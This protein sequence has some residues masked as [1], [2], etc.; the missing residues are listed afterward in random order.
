MSVLRGRRLALGAVATLLALSCG[1]SFKTAPSRSDAGAGAAGGSVAKGS[2]GDDDAG[3]APSSG[4]KGTDETGGAVTAIDGGASGGHVATG[5]VP[6]GGSGG[7]ASGGSAGVTT[8]A[9]GRAGAMS[10]SGGAAGS[11]QTSTGGG[12]GAGGAPPTGPNIPKNG[13][14]LWLRADAGVTAT[15]GRVSRW[16]DQ[17][18][19]HD[20]ATQT[21]ASLQPTLVADG[22]AGHPALRF[23]GMDDF[24]QITNAFDVETGGVTI[25][26]VTVAADSQACSSIFETSNG[27]EI[28]DISF[29]TNVGTLNFE[30]VTTANEDVTF[31]AQTPLVLGA[32]LDGTGA[33]QILKNGVSEATFSGFT[34][35]P[36]LERLQTFV[37]KSL[38]TGCTTFSG[39]VGEVIVYER[40]LT[41]KEVL[42]VEAALATEFGCCTTGS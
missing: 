28:D 33:G 12:G 6:S 25:F 29:G 20:D 30:S 5:G 9:G 13:L 38:Y 34:A 3:G 31:P 23:D 1:D 39:K 7:R 22:I 8:S 16:A 2:G 19:S 41:L 32:I 11:P 18:P 24:L 21:G 17:S 10:S 42:D 37:G 14:V 36:M 27:R 26:A 4:G 40:A 15:N 35:P